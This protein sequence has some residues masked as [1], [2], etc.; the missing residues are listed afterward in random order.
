MM[1]AVDA[2]ANQGCKA[3]PSP[4]GTNC[5]AHHF[6]LKMDVDDQED[7]FD[8]D[9]GS[10][11]IMNQSILDEILQLGGVQ[12][13]ELEDEPGLEPVDE[14]EEELP[15]EEEE[16]I[17]INDVVAP[18]GIETT[19]IPTRT[20]VPTPITNSPTGTPLA[21][22]R[23]SASS[24]S[25]GMIVLW[26]VLGLLLIAVI[27]GYLVYRRRY[28]R[29][30]LNLADDFDQSPLMK[31]KQ[32]HEHSVLPPQPMPA[33]EVPSQG[34]YSS[35]HYYQSYTNPRELHANTLDVEPRHEI[36]PLVPQVSETVGDT[37]YIHRIA[38]GD[39]GQLTQ[40]GTNEVESTLVEMQRPE[41]FH[42]SVHDGLSRRGTEATNATRDTQISQ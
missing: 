20:G 16:E 5:T 13:P 10:E 29:L 25:I 37:S 38:L 8:G 30:K 2:T 6:P 12:Q 15:I 35:P 1:E 39:E 22:P 24:F 34:N 14:E 26:V 9:Y 40:V 21:L 11:T 27:I 3:V 23:N 33:S 31:P 4:K 36:L 28:Q 7:P 19:Q 18:P 32:D 42:A 41:S 17:P